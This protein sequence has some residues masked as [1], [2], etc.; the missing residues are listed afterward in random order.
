M[1][2][3]ERKAEIFRRAN[4]RIAAKKRKKRLILGAVVP[5]LLVAVLAFPVGRMLGSAKGEEKA[6]AIQM[7]NQPSIAP[8][9]HPA[10]QATCPELDLESILQSSESPTFRDDPLDTSLDILYHLPPDIYL[11]SQEGERIQAMQVSYF[12]IQV[13]DGQE[14]STVQESPDILEPGVVDK[15]I[16]TSYGYLILDASNLKPTS[17]DAEYWS[18]TAI[19]KESAFNTK[20]NE[21][22]LYF[23]EGNDQ[24]FP[25]SSFTLNSN[26]YR[27]ELAPGENIY[28]IQI[29]WPNGTVYCSFR[30]NYKE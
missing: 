16:D 25:S 27:L 28:Q 11:Y 30:V 8:G 15:Q 12:W 17:V 10:P 26:L 19:G 22:S 29:Q 21:A 7:E 20:G 18:I 6:T 5:V 23:D 24:L 9:D 2:F 1:N 3:E 13:V 4:G 14:I